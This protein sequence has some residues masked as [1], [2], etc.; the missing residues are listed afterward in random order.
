MHVS[1]SKT[2]LQA[3]MHCPAKLISLTRVTIAQSLPSACTPINPL[4]CALLKHSVNP[5]HCCC[6][7]SHFSS[8]GWL[9]LTG[10]SCMVIYSEPEHSFLKKTTNPQPPSPQTTPH[11]SIIS[12]AFT[13]II[14]FSRWIDLKSWSDLLVT[15]RPFLYL[16]GLQPL[17]KD[18]AKCCLLIFLKGLYT[19]HMGPSDHTAGEVKGLYKSTH[20]ANT[21][22]WL[23]RFT[24]FLV[25]ASFTPTRIQTHT[26]FPA[27]FV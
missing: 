20:P 12:H 15:D 24:S 25:W 18:Y 13:S 7:D 9:L 11:S 10:W 1:S 17:R 19:W 22:K 3:T 4:M 6:N 23:F 26:H 8:K 27:H 2:C 21:H 5:G 14:F 16:G